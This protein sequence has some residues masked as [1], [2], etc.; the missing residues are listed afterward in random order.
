MQL[1]IFLFEIFFIYTLAGDE[2]LFYR[3][4]SGLRMGTSYSDSIA[5]LGVVPRTDSKASLGV[6]PSTHA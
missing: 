3:Q 4:L 2:Q 6:V 5:S 1:A